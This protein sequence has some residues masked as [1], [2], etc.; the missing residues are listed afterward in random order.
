TII[1]RVFQDVG[2]RVEVTGDFFGDEE[3][4]AKLE[5][6]LERLSLSDVSILGVDSVELL[7][8]VKECVNRKQS[9]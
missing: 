7:E 5:R 2:I 8:K 4:L 9:V 6:D 1:L 3:D